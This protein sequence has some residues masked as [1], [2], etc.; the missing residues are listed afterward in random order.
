[1]S[2]THGS[3]KSHTQ[4]RVKDRPTKAERRLAR[5][6]AAFESHG[7]NPGASQNPSNSSGTGHD[8]HRPGSQN[9]RKR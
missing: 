3:K 8:M 7:A 5:R 2:L 4:P 6:I 1:M 9:L